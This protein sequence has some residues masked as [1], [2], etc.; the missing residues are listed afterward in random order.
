LAPLGVANPVN[1]GRGG[2]QSAGGSPG[3]NAPDG[4]VTATGGALGVGGSGAGGGVNGG[5]GGGG[6]LYGGGGGGTELQWTNRPLGAGHGGGGSSFGPPETSFR[7]GVGDNLGDGWMKITYDPAADACG[8]PVS[9]RRTRGGKVIK[10][11]EIAG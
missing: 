9:S 4:A 7:N 3:G 1:G 5:G 11:R 10:A 8:F 2:T 6:G